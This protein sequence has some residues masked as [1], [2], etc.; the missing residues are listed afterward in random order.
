MKQK[1]H[2][3]KIIVHGI[4]L[5]PKKLSESRRKHGIKETYNEKYEARTGMKKPMYGKKHT[6]KE[7]EEAHKHMKKHGG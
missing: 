2:A 4:G 5:S 6:K 3:G 7:L 1:E